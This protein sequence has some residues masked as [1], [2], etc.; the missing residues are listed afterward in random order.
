M[1]DSLPER[2][3]EGLH[4]PGIP[5]IW[6]GIDIP[7]IPSMDSIFNNIKNSIKTGLVDPVEKGF[8]EAIDKVKT[9]VTD[10]INKVKS[11]LEGMINDLK[12]G[13]DDA[14]AKVKGWFDG[15]VAKI[16][17]GF[18]VI[19]DFFNDFVKRMKKM[20]D[21]IKNIF[22]GIG[23]EFTG[24]GQGLNL[25]FTNIGVLFKWTGEFIFSYITCGVQYISNLHRCI[26][27][28]ILDVLG[29]LSY[30]IFFRFPIWLIN[31]AF[32]YDLTPANDN[33]WKELDT[34]DKKIYGFAGFHIIHYTK[35]I[36]DLCYN[37][38][39]MKIDALKNKVQEINNDFLVKMPELLNKGVVEIKSGGDDF[40]GAFK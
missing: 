12:K 33:M 8:N 23:T 9:G 40:M 24:L 17:D 30:A 27:F 25:G 11:T 35:Q 31:I 28:Y 4:I 1:E 3:V 6:D 16:T 34:L 5:H 37:C 36:R 38:K 29:Q 21:G 39:R 20:G 2:V 15:I 18:K 19:T 22:G 13:F 14:M 10:T 7:D 26:F 32:K